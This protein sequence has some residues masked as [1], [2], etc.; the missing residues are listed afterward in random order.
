MTWAGG[1]ALALLLAVGLSFMGQSA[2]HQVASAAPAQRAWLGR[3]SAPEL[4]STIHFYDLQRN[5]GYTVWLRD[6]AEGKAGS[7]VFTLS[8]HT[9]L[10]A[11]APITQAEDNSFIQDTN[12][13]VSTNAA[14][15]CPWRAA[16]ESGKYSANLSI[17][18]RI[19]ASGLVAYAQL[20][21][22]TICGAKQSG[23]NILMESG[24]TPTACNDML[25]QAGSAVQQYDSSIVSAAADRSQDAWNKVYAQVSQTT[26]G[27]YTPEQFAAQLNKQI[28]SVGQITAV[29]PITSAPV[30]Q[31]DTAGQAFFAVK[32]QIT[33][34]HNGTTT[35]RDT[36]SYYLM[37]GGQW[38]FWF[39]A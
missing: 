37:E 31:Y 8:D 7:F 38:V 13:A 35:T 16:T 22:Y 30:L 10:I 15:I 23:E 1:A 21:Y 25:A 4:P 20:R 28:E 14:V 9:Q 17:Q 33:Y 5:T 34:T 19:D 12:Q 29:S 2:S 39:S 26:R 24:C 36:T 3:A 32:Q 6:T 27:Q 11:F 18:A